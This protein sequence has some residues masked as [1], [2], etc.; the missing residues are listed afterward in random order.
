MDSAPLNTLS[1]ETYIGSELL[2]LMLKNPDTVSTVLKRLKQK[3]TEWNQV[4][5]GMNAKWKEQLRH[6]ILRSTD[7]R[8]CHYRNK[9]RKMTLPHCLVDEIQEMKCNQTKKVFSLNKAQKQLCVFPKLESL[10]DI[11]TEKKLPPEASLLLQLGQPTIHSALFHLICSAVEQSS[12]PRH[13]K[14]RVII[15]WRHF[16]ADFIRLQSNEITQCKNEKKSNGLV[17]LDELA[18]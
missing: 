15:F 13:D 17:V 12:M 18:F 9:E 1:K 7:H 14:K 4:R 6:N 11:Q 8:S 3:D 5:K 16:F 10:D 2:E